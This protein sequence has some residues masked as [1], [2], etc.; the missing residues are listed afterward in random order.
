MTRTDAENHSRCLTFSEFFHDKIHT[1]KDTIHPKVTSFFHP[2]DTPDLSFTSLAF[3]LTLFTSS[4]LPKY[5][6]SS[7]NHHLSLLQWTSYLPTSMLNSCSSAFSDKISNLANLLH[8]S[9]LASQYF[10]KSKFKLA[11]VTSFLKKPGFDKDSS[12]NY[13][14]ISNLNNILKLLEHLILARIPLHTTSS[15]NFNPLQSAYQHIIPMSHYCYWALDN[16][17]HAV[18]DG[19]STMLIWLDLSAAFDTIDYSILLNHLQT[20]FSINYVSFC[21]VPLLSCWQNQ[22]VFIGGSMSSATQCFT[23]IP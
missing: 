8:C 4:P 2:T 15:C 13:C 7:V 5:L 23:A 6:A 22:F 14:P 12:R 3:H 17:Y 21:L 11:Q 9:N 1:L 16:I 18:D 20:S 19:S 10:P